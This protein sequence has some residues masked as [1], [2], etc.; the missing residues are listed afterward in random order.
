MVSLERHGLGASTGLTLLG[1]PGDRSERPF[2][3]GVEGDSPGLRGWASFGLGATGG[4]CMPEER[5]TEDVVD[6]VYVISSESEPV[7]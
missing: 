4:L 3:L 2:P 1:V 7:V 5:K 6:F